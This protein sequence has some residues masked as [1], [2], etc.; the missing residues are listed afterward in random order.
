MQTMPVR[1]RGGGG[2]WV[3]CGL[4]RQWGMLGRRRGWTTPNESAPDMPEHEERW[5]ASGFIS[6]PTA[7]KRG[8]ERQGDSP[9]V[10]QL[11]PAG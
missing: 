2:A 10:A 5:K 9:E 7:E 4:P 8:P 1:D 6:S 11:K 3:M